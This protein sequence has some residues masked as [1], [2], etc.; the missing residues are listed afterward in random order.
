MDTNLNLRRLAAIV[1]ALIAIG[2]FLWAVNVYIPMAQ[3]IKDLLNVFVF[4]ATV[5]FILRAVGLWPALTRLWHDL[6]AR[7]V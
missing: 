2:V 1:L 5:T 7:R 4:L 3:S 6:T